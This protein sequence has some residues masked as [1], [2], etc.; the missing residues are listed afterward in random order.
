MEKNTIEKQT[1]WDFV[2]TDSEYNITKILLQTYKNQEFEELGKA[3]EAFYQQSIRGARHEA[4]FELKLLMEEVLYCKVSKEMRT[5]ERWEKI[6]RHRREIEMIM[7]FNECVTNDDLKNDWERALDSAKYVAEVDFPE[8]ET[9]KSL[10]WN[11]VI[12]DEY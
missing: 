1:D 9:V 6:C 5:Q 8:I 4:F 10:S 11:E 7:E 2:M 3:L 12:T